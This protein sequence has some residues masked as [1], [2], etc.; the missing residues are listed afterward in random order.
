MIR[1][2]AILTA[3]AIVIGLA[4]LIVIGMPYVV[5]IKPKLSA[6]EQQLAGYQYEK[7]ELNERN[8]Q[9]FSGLRNPMTDAVSPP[10]KA[11]RNGYP[12]ENLA[13]LAPPGKTGQPPAA[14][15]PPG[16][17]FIVIRDRSRM[18][19]VNGEVVREGD[20]TNQ[21]KIMRITKTGVLIK[22]QEGQRWVYVE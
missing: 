20:R 7:V 8:R 16:V 1:H 22:N 9:V 6:Q 13:D 11:G 2:N 18:A 12:G 5:H 19:I 3:I 21:G 10:G 4:G 17:S 14:G 15:Q